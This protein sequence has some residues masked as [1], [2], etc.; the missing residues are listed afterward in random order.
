MKIKNIKLKRLRAIQYTAV[1]FLI[2]VGIVNYLDRSVLS[3]VNCTISADL[4]LSVSQ[5]GLLILAF[6]LS[7]AIAQLPVGGLLDRFGARLVLSV[8]M[9][10]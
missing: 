6:S 10:V 2:T 1:G 7:Y 9:F 5:M 8:S 4:N 3:I